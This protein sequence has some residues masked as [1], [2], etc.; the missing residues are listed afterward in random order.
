M[1]KKS[2]IH[3]SQTKALLSLTKASLLASLRNPSSVFF[4]FFFPIIFIVIF[5]LVGN[6][7]ST[8]S[9]AFKSDTNKENP[10]YK[11]FTEN[12]IV[13]IKSDKSIE[14]FKEDLKK[15]DL[16]AIIDVQQNESGQF[17]TNIE[18]SA[19]APQGANIVLT[20]ANSVID[21][22]NLAAANSNFTPFK[23][24][25][26]QIE[27]R[28]YTTI[29]FI[30][31]GQLGF[32]LLSTAVFSTAFS[33]INLRQT[34][35][36]KRIFATPVKPLVILLAIGLS[37]LIF[38]LVQSIVIIGAGALF[39]NFTLA[40]GIWTFL[41]MVLLSIFALVVF[42]GFGFIVASVAKNEDAAAPVANLIT[43]PQLFLS[44]A[45]FPIDSFPSW[46]QTVSKF[47]PLT[48]LNEALRKIAFEGAPLTSVAQEVLYLAIGGI[49]VYAISVKIF[50]WE[51]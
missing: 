31:P 2:I 16:D 46:L 32:A 12:D 40:N 21:K 17:V 10:I 47:L 30:L 24:D 11:V 7:T 51:K 44:G 23:L 43:F 36:I 20:V 33:F 8:V 1:S 26:T 35:V 6:S 15:G 29:D 42:L 19:A 13:K 28:K 14:E 41:S 27:G 38:A 49:I 45:F 3:Y 22:A 48:H 9:V 5:G 25:T 37:K 18:T 4:G 34:L 39:F 50:R